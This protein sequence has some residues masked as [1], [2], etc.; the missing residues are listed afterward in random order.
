MIRNAAAQYDVKDVLLAG[1]V[2]ANQWIR[3]QVEGKLA[4][5]Q[6]RV[7][8]PESRFSGDNAAGCAHYAYRQGEAHD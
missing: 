3:H 5:R 2:S 7:W 8:V 4:K 6:I 1:G